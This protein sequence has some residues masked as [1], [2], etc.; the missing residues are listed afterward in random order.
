MEFLTD[1]Y[2]KCGAMAIPPHMTV[3][4]SDWRV[5]YRH[6]SGRIAESSA[7]SFLPHLDEGAL[8]VRGTLAPSTGTE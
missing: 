8:W 2:R 6:L 5:V 4:P 7:P 3:G 1:R